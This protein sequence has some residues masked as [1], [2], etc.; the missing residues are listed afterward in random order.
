MSLAAGVRTRLDSDAKAAFE[1]LCVSRG[2]SMSDELRR[3]I[4]AELGIAELPEDGRIGA[5][6]PA[7]DKR[8][9]VVNA[10]LT[11]DEWK[12]AQPIIEA[13]AGSVTAWILALVRERITSG[14]HLRD[15]ELD[16]LEKATF[17]L[18]S[19]GRNLNQIVRAVND[20]NADRGRFDAKYA[21][22]LAQYIKGTTDGINALVHAASSRESLS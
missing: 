21:E 14:P 3:L 15:S 12:A 6:D 13:E 4:Y 18:R 1:R 2:T 10:R 7:P 20:G 9:K 11:T 5:D 17:Q 22:Q 19:I 16:A 8:W